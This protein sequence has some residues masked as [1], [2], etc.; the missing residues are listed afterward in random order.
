MKRPLLNKK[1]MTPPRDKEEVQPTLK[2][3][4]WIA[5]LASICLGYQWH[6]SHK[7]NATFTSL[8]HRIAELEEQKAFALQKQEELKLEI[9]SEQ[10]PTYIEMMLMK[11]LGLMPNGAKKVYFTEE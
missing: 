4:F 3:W 5:I 8:H 1:E 7:Q 9:H 10:D 2:S 11:N 6:M